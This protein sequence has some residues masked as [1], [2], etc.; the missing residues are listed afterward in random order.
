M[1]KVEKLSFSYT[2]NQETLSDVS[3]DIKRGSWVSIL[4]HNG[5]GKS[6]LSKL[7]V[8]LLLAK[9]GTIT[10]DGLELNEQNLI[11]IRKKVGI[12]FQN[13]DSQ[14][15]GVTVKHDIAF[16]LENLQVPHEQLQKDVL[17]Y[18]TLV[19]MKDFLDHEPQNLSGGQKQRVAIASCLAMN[20]DLIILDEAT[21]M[22]DPKGVKEISELV[23]D[24]NRNYN[25][26]ILTITHDVELA[27]KSDHCLILNEGK[28]VLQGKPEDIFKEKEILEKSNLKLP[29]SLEVFYKILND[30]SIKNKK[31][32]LDALC[33]F[34]LTK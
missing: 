28:L 1:L 2:K 3:F 17:K 26:T 31:E 24:L 7:I 13:P 9:Q 12:V 15:V 30:D 29:I 4:G 5:S 18:A 32:V 11:D 8:G 16:G 10:V 25:K 33:Q 21:S 20:Q 23:K 14:F 6:T 34:S 27:F 22:L 19:G